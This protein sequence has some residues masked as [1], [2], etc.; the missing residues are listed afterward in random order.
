VPWRIFWVEVGTALLFGFLYWYYGLSLELAVAAAYSSLFILLL[1]IDLEHQLILNKVVYPTAAAALL[2]DVFLP[3][4]GILLGAAGGAVGFALLLLPALIFRGGMGWGDVKMAGL[5]GI[6][7]GFPQIF[8]AIFGAMIVGGTVAAIL[9][10]LRL[11]GR[12]DAIPYGPFL[13][14]AAIATMLF[15]GEIL[16]W[17]LSL[18]G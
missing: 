1:V 2:A 13:S 5:V 11:K 15:G 3:E 4:P 8:V 16:T 6:V 12:K 9:L 17:Y 14:I 18:F 7:V 10:L